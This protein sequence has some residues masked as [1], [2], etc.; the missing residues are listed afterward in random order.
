MKQTNKHLLNLKYSCDSLKIKSKMQPDNRT[1]GGG[2]G[3]VGGC[4]QL[5]YANIPCLPPADHIQHVQQKVP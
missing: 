1:G 3:G 4:K 5:K 2:G